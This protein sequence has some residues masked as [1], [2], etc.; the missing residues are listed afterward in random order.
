MASN[1]ELCI[2]EV[3]SWWPFISMNDQL[4]YLRLACSAIRL[5]K[6]LSSING[7]DSPGKKITHTPF[8]SYLLH[9]FRCKFFSFMRVACTRSK[10]SHWDVN[11]SLWEGNYDA[12]KWL[13]NKHTAG[14]WQNSKG[15]G[16]VYRHYRGFRALTPSMY[17]SSQHSRGKGKCFHLHFK[18]GKEKTKAAR[19]LL[20]F[21][22]LL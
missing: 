22:I 15:V 6:R 17:A 5:I 11:I 13:I 18:D 2:Y 10:C 14:K 7:R 16:Q 9:F 1:P 3:F 8:F 21:C 19:K 12:Y 4:W 20:K